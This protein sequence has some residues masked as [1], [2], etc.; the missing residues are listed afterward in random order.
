MTGTGSGEA[1]H[2]DQDAIEIASGVAVALGVEIEQAGSNLFVH[3]SAQAT[4]VD[5]A[6]APARRLHQH[7]IDAHF[8]V[9]VNDHR[10]A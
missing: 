4:A 5:H 2:F 7:M 10:R 9:F 8:T 3:M 6:H 1:G